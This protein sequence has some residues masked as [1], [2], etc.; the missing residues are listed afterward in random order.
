M[1]LILLNKIEELAISIVRHKRLYFKRFD[2]ILVK[3]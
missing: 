2:K 1:A 3:I